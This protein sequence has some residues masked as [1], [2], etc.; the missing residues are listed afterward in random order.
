[1]TGSFFPLRCTANFSPL[2]LAMDPAMSYAR[3]ES[4]PMVSS[5]NVSIRNRTRSGLKVILV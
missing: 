4:R 5:S 3:L 2:R 1:L